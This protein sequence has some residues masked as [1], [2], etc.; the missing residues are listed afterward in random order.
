M[1]WSLAALVAACI[2]CASDVAGSAA[3]DPI[4]VNAMLPLTGFGAF[5]GKANQNALTALEAL[6]NKSGGISGRPLH[7]VYLDEQSSAQTAVELTNQLIAKNVQWMLG[8]GVV[9]S[10]RATEPL[11]KNGPL[12][13]CQS[14]AMHP[15]KGSFLFSSSVSTQ[16]QVLVLIRYARKRS[17]NRVA[18]IT[19]TDASGQDGDQAIDAALALPENKSM[20]LVRREHFN[21]TDFTV[22][23]QM[24]NIKAADPQV[25]FLWTPG[26]PFGTLIRG[27]SDA[28]IDAPAM[29]S[30]GNMTY[31]QI[32]QYTTMPKEI[33]FPG[34][35]Y[36]LAGDTPPGKAGA[37]QRVF[38]DAM[39]A[40]NFPIDL[41]SGFLWDPGMIL[42]NALRKFG[43]NATATQVHDYIENLHDFVGI[44]GPYD[45]RG[46]NQRGISADNIA[47]MRWDATKS[48]WVPV[49]APGTLSK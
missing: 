21:I 14:P 32:R 11:L 20:K 31:G 43:P 13:F 10:C 16:D 6:V 40:L 3:G 4:E 30:N 34:L 42:V 29:T 15:A 35:T 12:Q 19:S 7:F 17:W 9:A 44:S 41:Q 27:F 26:T 48:D 36:M 39:H 37:P 49:S 18:F 2:L 33:Y 28:G 24:T 38:Q 22:T 1:K 45:F 23:A 47:V 8:P 25:V 5:S 46:G